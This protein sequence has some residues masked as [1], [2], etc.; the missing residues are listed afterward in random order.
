MRHRRRVRHL[1]CLREMLCVRRF[2][3]P[4]REAIEPALTRRLLA[5]TEVD[6]L[7]PRGRRRHLLPAAKALHPFEREF[8]PVIMAREVIFVTHQTVKLGFLRNH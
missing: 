1:T 4:S 5:P 2:G 7:K 3:P 6:W 8:V